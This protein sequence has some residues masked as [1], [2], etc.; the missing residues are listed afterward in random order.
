[1]Q[2]HKWERVGWELLGWCMLIASFIFSDAVF[3]IGGLCCWIYK[4]VRFPQP[5][6]MMSIAIPYEEY[7][8]ANDEHHES[9]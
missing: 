9:K 1:M 6:I 5:T 2:N 8:K 3:M 4:E 7:K